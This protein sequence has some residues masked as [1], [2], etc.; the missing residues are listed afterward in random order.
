MVKSSPSCPMPLPFPG[1]GG[2]S[3]IQ[4]HKRQSKLFHSPCLPGRL[5][6]AFILSDVQFI[7]HTPAQHFV[8]R[9]GPLLKIAACRLSS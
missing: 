6:P 2:F 9:R 8:N 3:E 4:N 5:S 1:P 7:G